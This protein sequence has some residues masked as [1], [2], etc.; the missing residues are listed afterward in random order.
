[1]RRRYIAALIVL[2]ST[3]VGF[4]VSHFYPQAYD[5][6][7]GFMVAVAIL[8]KSALISFITVSK[9]K[10]VAFLKNLTLLQAVILLIKRW[11]LDNVFAKWLRENIIKYLIVPIKSI[12]RYYR[13]LNLKRKIEN[14]VVPFIS[15]SATLWLIYQSGYL[16]NL[17]LFTELKVFIIGLSK[18]ILLIFSKILSFMLDSWITPILEVFALSYFL[19]KLEE[20]LGNDNII[21]KVIN[22]LGEKLNKLVWFFSD[23]NRKYIDSVIN[24]RV[25]KKSKQI[26]NS[27]E[28][29]VYRKKT[30]YEYEQFEKLESKI[31]KGHIDAYFSFKGIEKIK[32]KKELYSLINKKTKDHLDIIAFVSR[33][34]YGELV[35]ENV[36]NSYYHDIFLL[37]GVATS[38]KDGVKEHREKD[39]DYTDFWILNTSNYPVKL[40]RSNK[41]EEKLIEPKSVTLIKTNREIDYNRDKICFEFNGKQECAIV[42]NEGVK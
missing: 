4:V 31:L 13:S 7:L 24:E 3:V 38:H 33:D 11:F 34:K 30:E 18:T 25:S 2:F 28:Q 35:A 19:N 37:E 22:Q 10:I 5:I 16:D 23:I 41:Y 36:D 29:Y 21:I 40:L 39:L 6:L 20:W 1:M 8:F 9:L 26:A 42:L 32:D 12:I 17:L 14:F 15:V 27:L